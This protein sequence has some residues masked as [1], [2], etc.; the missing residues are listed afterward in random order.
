MS[1]PAY[2]ELLHPDRSKRFYLTEPVL[3]IGRSS[4]CDI[5]LPYPQISRRHARLYREGER[6]GIE[7]LKSVNG[8]GVNEKAVER[9]LL[10]DGDEI[11]LGSL[12]L[13]YRNPSSPPIRLT[14]ECESDFQRTISFPISSSFFAKQEGPR[15]AKQDPGETVQ[16]IFN[17][18]KSLLASKDLN[19]V[20]SSVMDFI[21]EFLQA[22]RGFLMLCDENFQEPTPYVVKYRE[23]SSSSPKADPHFSK[24]IVNKVFKEGVAILTANAMKDNRFDSGASIV[25][26]QI[27]SCMCVPLWDEKR[28]MGLIYVDSRFRENVFQE[29]D[30]ELLSTIAVISAVAISQSQLREAVEREKSIREQLQR[31]HSPAVIN[32]ILESGKESFRASEE[33]DI[34]ILFADLCGFTPLSERRKP[35]QVANI[36]NTFFSA[37][38][39]IIFEKEG[40]LDKYI[41]DAVMAVFGAPFDQADHAVRAVQTAVDMCRTLEEMNRIGIFPE[42]LRMR[43]GINSGRVVAGDFGSEKRLE[44]TV[45][46]SPVNV[47]FRIESTVAQPGEILIGESTKSL[48][49]D[50]FPT[51]DLGPVNL[52]GIASSMHVYRIIH[53]NPAETGQAQPASDSIHQSGR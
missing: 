47:A 3:L 17:A 37:M 25:L 18:A 24:T 48:I 7:D 34:S 8:V 32:R 35:T 26:Q 22:D 44:Y 10:Q 29:K 30:L 38:T 15:L 19:T 49:D 13:A 33:K 1:N 6:Y 11:T 42:P 12:R 52:R 45:L 4:E 39:E 27:R 50:L 9:Q 5:V 2:L 43:I 46:G 36:L 41:G 31:Y 21:F 40:T 20:L 14:D 23:S 51:V 16:V 53:G 28:V